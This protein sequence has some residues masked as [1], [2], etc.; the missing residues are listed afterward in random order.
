MEFRVL[1]EVLELGLGG[2]LVARGYED[3][4]VDGVGRLVLAVPGE[5]GEA[6]D[7][8]GVGRLGHHGR[9]V[10]P[11]AEAEA[12]G[13]GPL[14]VEGDVA[15]GELEPVREEDRRALDGGARGEEVVGRAEVLDGV[16]RELV[17]GFS[18]VAREGLGRGG[19]GALEGQGADAERRG[20]VAKAP[21]RGRGVVGVL[22]EVEGRVD[23]AVRRALEEVLLGREERDD[24]RDVRREDVVRREP[25]DIAAGSVALEG[26]I[27]LPR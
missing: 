12:V 24:V 2:P 27:N 11:E 3:V 1:G 8:A 14:A 16:R 26:K 6:D 19:A 20:R 7:V 25:R 22:A 5:G 23:V 13:G 10:A 17:E 9:G 4:R 21:V 15:R 18:E